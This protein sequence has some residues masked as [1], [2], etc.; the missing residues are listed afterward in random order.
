[1]DLL[2]NHVLRHSLALGN[3]RL[4]LLGQLHRDRRD[5][6]RLQVAGVHQRDDRDRH[7]EPAETLELHEELLDPRGHD[8][9]ECMTTTDSIDVDNLKFK[10]LFSP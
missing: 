10:F 3:V 2:G 8:R 5:R 9:P 7:E 4:H 6:Q 1:M